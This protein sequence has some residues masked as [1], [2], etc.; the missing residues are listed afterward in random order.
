[1]IKV[2]AR[3]EADP[4]DTPDVPSNNKSNGQWIKDLRVSIGWAVAKMARVC[5]APGKFKS[6]HWEMLEMGEKQMSTEVRRK[7]L[8]VVGQEKERL[9]TSPRK[10][11]ENVS[12]I[13]R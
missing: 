12:S 7:F 5:N 4:Y 3:T 2:R 9:R 8:Q 10:T 13:V 1:M 6:L 11:G